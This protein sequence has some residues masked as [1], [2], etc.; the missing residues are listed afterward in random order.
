MVTK[1]NPIVF[2]DSFVQTFLPMLLLANTRFQKNSLG[3]SNRGKRGCHSSVII[4]CNLVGLS[5]TVQWRPLITFF[6][7]LKISYMYKKYVQFFQSLSTGSFSVEESVHMIIGFGASTIFAAEMVKYKS[8]S[9][10]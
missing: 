8:Q 4:T 3:R 10:G 2:G 6:L 9:S 1:L 5:V 7:A